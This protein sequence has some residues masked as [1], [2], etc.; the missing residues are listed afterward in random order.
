MKANL[1]KFLGILL[2]LMILI[3]LSTLISCEK[4]VK[5]DEDTASQDITIGTDKIVISGLGDDKEISV[6][7]LKRMEAVTMVAS[8][9]NSDNEKSTRKVKGI[10]LEDILQKYF[11]KSQKDLSAIIFFAG[12]GYSV[13]I[14]K[15]IINSRDIILAYELDGRPVDSETQPFRAVVPD[16]RSLYWVK[17]I[18]KIEIIENRTETELNKIIFLDTAAGSIEQQDFDYYGVKDKAVSAEDLLTKFSQDTLQGAIYIE[19]SDGLKKVEEA[20]IFKK[21]LIKIGG[22][23]TPAF[24]AEDLP[25]GMWVKNILKFSYGPIVYFSIEEALAAF[26]NKQTDDLKGVAVKDIINTAGLPEAQ[27][28]LFTALDGYSTE[29]GSS[30]I[31]KGLIYLNEKGEPETYFKDLPKNSE[32]KNL[33]SIEIVK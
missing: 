31:G 27:S 1:K 25:K 8:T 6:E 9:I 28:Y 24:L 12:D 26:E 5:T 23:D 32:V 11:E 3:T 15:E 33:L 30:D 14:P 19:A 18:V 16:E 4:S 2:V 17:N 22:E 21:A 10:L 7:E 13:E 20:D 29:I